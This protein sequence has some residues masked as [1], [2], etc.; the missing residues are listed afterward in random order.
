MCKILSSCEAPNLEKIV[1][2]VMAIPVGNDFVEH[3]FSVMKN[4]WTDERNR[5]IVRQ[6]KAE[7]CI[8]FNYSLSCTDFYNYISKDRKII[9]T[10]KSDKKYSFK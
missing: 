8:K 4:L 5:L 1:S 2:A 10:A 6:A 9:E 7:L 3:I